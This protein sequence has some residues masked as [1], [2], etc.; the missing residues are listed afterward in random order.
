MKPTSAPKIYLAGPLGFTEAGRAY[1][2]DVVIKK[3]RDAGYDPLDPWDVPSDILEVF[4]M[5]KGTRTIEALRQAN[6]KAGR[7]NAEFIRDAVA[8]LAILDGHD[9]D[10]GT[11][12]EIG[13]AAAL[14]KP[15]VGLRTDERVAGDNEATLVNLQVEWF[16]KASGGVI[17]DTGIDDATAKLAAVL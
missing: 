5:P 7:R 17:L 15:V 11:A 6:E 2:N 8:V 13:Y 3:V 16:I 12:A 4:D 10:S 14:E 9:V 1:H